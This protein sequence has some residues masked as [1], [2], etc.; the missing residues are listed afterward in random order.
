MFSKESNFTTYIIAE[1]E[2]VQLLK[3]MTHYNYIQIWQW[4][5]AG[6]VYIKLDPFIG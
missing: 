5:D 6:F 1:S 2:I 4:R 3:S